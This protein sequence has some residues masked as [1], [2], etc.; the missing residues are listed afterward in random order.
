MRRRP[1]PTGPALALCL[2][3]VILPATTTPALAQQIVLDTM[4]PW[5]HHHELAPPIIYDGSTPVALDDGPDWLNRRVTPA[6]DDWAAPDFDDSHWY[7]ATAMG[8]TRSPYTTR[9]HVR[10]RFEVTDPAAVADLELTVGYFG[11]AVVYVNGQEVA[12]GHLPAGALD[13]DTLAEPYPREAFV[14]D[15]GEAIA[16]GDAGRQ[17]H[18]N[19][20]RMRWLEAEIPAD[21]LRE[22]VNVV[23]IEIVRAGYHEALR[24][25][26]ARLSEGH[27]RRAN[28]AFDLSWPTAFLR[29]VQLT[30]GRADGLVPNAQR[31]A[32]VQIYNSDA[33]APDFDADWADP[34]EPL[35]PVRL[36]GVRNGL[37][38]GKVVVAADRPIRDLAV[39]VADLAG[40]DGAVIDPASV[41]VRYGHGH[42]RWSLTYPYTYEQ[43][44]Y[45]GSVT[46]LGTLAERPAG[47]YDT[48]EQRVGEIEPAPRAPVGGAV[49]PVWVTVAIPDDAAAGTYRG[50]LT[51]TMAGE[52]PRTVELEV[53]VIDWTLPQP[54]NWKL[55]VELWQSPD[56]L[57]LEYDVELWSDEHFELI[58]QSMRLM[59]EVGTSTVYIPL[60]AETNRGNEQSMVR[61]VD[62]GEGGYRFDY[63]P[64]ERY[65]DTAQEELGDLSLVTFVV[66]DIYVGAQERAQTVTN[67]Q[68]GRALAALGDELGDGPVVTMIDASG[69]AVRRELPMY[70]EMASQW[71]ELWR[72][73]DERLAARGLTEQAAFGLLSDLW[74]TRDDVEFWAEIAPGVGWVNH[75]HHGFNLR[76]ERPIHDIARGVYQT[77]VWNISFAS[78]PDEPQHGWNRPELLAYYNRNS[79]FMGQG[80]SAWRHYSEMVITGDMRGPGRLG[81]DYWSAVRDDRGRRR[82]QVWARYPQSSWRNLDLHNHVLAP[83]PDGPASTQ[84]YEMFREGAQLAETR[85]YLESVLLDDDRRGRLSDELVQRVHDMLAQRLEA[86]FRGRSTLRLT[87]GPTDYA[88]SGGGWRS[89]PGIAGNIWYVGSSD[90]QARERELYELAAEVATA[91]GE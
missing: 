16:G 4:G 63:E 26:A 48:V 17:A 82:G 37:Y 30:A 61:W 18:Y 25:D 72:G 14:N 43:N 62:D 56:T 41:R 81:A 6:P 89:R 7:R 71:R 22:G 85:I 75:S 68:P 78:R 58:A 60:L 91:L 52:P 76:S 44:P 29:R 24:A 31:P 53:D 35:R 34:N 59:R 65:L 66:W 74:A 87:R 50:E 10:S 1:I 73:V 40:P 28:T 42:G 70:R 15:D 20:H 27:T 86:I 9:Q 67:G 47:Q 80:T 8:G 33:M 23:A 39:E 88:T 51:V 32:G 69:D 49:V 83:G 54:A 5:R 21:V 90:W 77:R 3:A 2:A 13:A 45:A 64:M 36:A 55:W 57:A 12:R 19:E 11:G 38:S 84:R 46:Y 79:G